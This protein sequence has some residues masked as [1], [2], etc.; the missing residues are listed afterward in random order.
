[1]KNSFAKS[2]IAMAVLLSNSNAFAQNNSELLNELK[3][4]REEMKQ[5]KSE[6]D[7]M[8]SQQVRSIGASQTSITQNG[9]GESAR[10]KSNSQSMNA[11]TA[12]TP[13]SAPMPAEV[14][15]SRLS[16][17]GYGEMYYTR[18]R[19]NA[20]DAMATARRG[21]LGFAYRFNDRTRF[22]AELEIENAVVSSTDKGEAAFEQLYVEH[23]INDRL[24][25]KAGLF[26]L[27]IGYMNET[28]EPTRYFG[29]T[30]NLVE[31]AII[32]TTW[33]EMGV[34]LQGSDGEGLRWNAGLVTSFD[35]N[36]W[37]TDSAETKESPLGAI[38]QEGQQAKA[39]SGAY[40][41]ALNYDGIPGVNVGGSLFSGGIGQKQAT[42]ATPSA[43]VNL[44]EMHTK[45]QVG[46]WDLSALA[47]RG[48]FIGVGAFNASGASGSNPVPDQFRGWYTQAAYRLWKQG[49]YSLVPFSRYERVNTAIGYSG[50]P[51]GVAPTTEPDQR[52]MT[53]GASFYLHPQVVIKVDTQRYFNNSQ[54]DRFNLG[55]GFHY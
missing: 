14:A 44:V 27:P 23:D 43:R 26:L 48:Q 19:H 54:L 18:P 37:P 8:K 47:A 12:L 25:A 45:W 28:H 7:A 55:L 9:S 32:P 53:L 31:T 42:I 17:F 39:A 22:A 34:G 16:M 10:E 15:D 33:R 49:D 20:S 36:K 4:L 6:L 21:V 52:V 3:M 24:T 11:S 29:V 51:L 1:M 41:G 40:Y 35:L 38:H 30:R 2:T 13:S 50:L 5:M 46:R